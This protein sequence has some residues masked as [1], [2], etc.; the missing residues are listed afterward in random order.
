MGRLFEVVPKPF[1]H[2]ALAHREDDR[3][4]RLRMVSGEA[5]EALAPRGGDGEFHRRPRL[6]ALRIGT[7][8]K[9]RLNSS[10]LIDLARSMSPYHSLLINALPRE[11][12]IVQLREIA[13]AQQQEV[14]KKEKE[15]NRFS[16]TKP[17]STRGIGIDDGWYLTRSLDIDRSD[18]HDFSSEVNLFQEIAK[19]LANWQ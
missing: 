16:P 18:H 17:H 10:N 2:R 9:G 13:T 8:F 6:P 4:H 3:R 11:A 7:H 5:P 1:E 15:R 12:R 19:I 14:T